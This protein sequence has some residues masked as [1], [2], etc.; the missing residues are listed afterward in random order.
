MSAVA[1]GEWVWTCR[2]GFEADLAE[3]L[4]VAKG[5]VV[6]EALVASAPPPEGTIPVFARQAT[7]VAAAIAPIPAVAGETVAALAGAGPFALHAWVPDSDPGNARSAEATAL[8]ETVLRARADLR[9]R[10]REVARPG[11]AEA[12]AL[13]PEAPVVQLVLPASGGVLA[14]A[15]PAR[16]LLST[17][18]GGRARMKVPGSAPSRSAMKLAEA[19]AWLGLGPDKGE[20]CVDLGAAPGG[21]TFVLL[22]RGAR[23]HAVDSAKLAPQVARDRRVTHVRRSAF[24]FEPPE[25]VDWLLCDM[26]QKPQDVAALLAKWAKRR[27]ARLLLANVKLPMKRRVA[28][29]AEAR[30]TLESGGWRD[31]RVRHLYHDR[32]EVTLFARR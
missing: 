3:E 20:V 7:P 29:V 22:A 12:G 32:D 15:L 8:R 13:P 4:R 18:P 10:I 21:W 9:D 5:R 24:D 2:A 14:G 6:E 30:R 27:W 28:A 1:A 17:F 26:V 11:A 25:P 19:F 31:L 23:V 16:A